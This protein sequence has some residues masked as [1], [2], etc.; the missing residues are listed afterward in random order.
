MA[1]QVNGDEAEL[2]LPATAINAIPFH[3]AQRLMLA[4]GTLWYRTLDAVQ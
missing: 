1:A 2:P 4:A 3:G